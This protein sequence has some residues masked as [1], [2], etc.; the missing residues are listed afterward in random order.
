MVILKFY[1]YN[2]KD[3]F[4]NILT[5]REFSPPFNAILKTLTL[6]VHFPEF[7]FFSASC[8]IIFVLGTSISSLL[9]IGINMNEVIKSKKSIL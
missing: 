1:C 9:D 2:F 3:L 5:G 4:T 6:Q 7:V 8:Y